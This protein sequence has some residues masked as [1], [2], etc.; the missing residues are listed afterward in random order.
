MSSKR[1]FIITHTAK[2]VE[3]NVENFRDKNKD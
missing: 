2:E 3:Y 1:A